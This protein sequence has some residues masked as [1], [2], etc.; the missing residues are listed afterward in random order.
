MW[1]LTQIVAL[2]TSATTYYTPWF[3]RGADNAFFTLE[4]IQETFG[5]TA[6]LVEAYSKNRED[7][8]SA[9]GSLVGT[10]TT[11]SGA[12]QEASCPALKELVRFVITFRASAVGQGV[13]F[14]FLQPTWYDTAV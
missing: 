11:L 1:M 12:F 14:R 13:V 9:P 3:P 4:K 6:F 10:F 7:E 8:G 2:N 5:T